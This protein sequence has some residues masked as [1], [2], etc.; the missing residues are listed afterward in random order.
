MAIKKRRPKQIVLK[1]HHQ[2]PY[3]KRQV[4]FLVLSCVVL[5]TALVKI[6]AWYGR[7]EAAQVP[8]VQ[9]VAP[10]TSNISIVRSSYGFSLAL[11]ANLFSVSATQLDSKDV[12]KTVGASDLQLN[13]PLT[14]VTIRPR[15][16][17]IERSE[18]ASQLI[19]QV[20]P[21]TSAYDTAKAKSAATASAGEVAATLFPQT[22]TNDLDV[23]ALSAKPDTLNGVPVL[24]TTYQYTP[25][26]NGGNSYATVWTGESQ[27][28][29]FAVKL[30]GLV[31]SSNMPAAYVKVLDS[32]TIVSNQG[33]KG[34]F[35]SL[36]APKVAADPSK[37]N[38]KYL[39]DDVSPA[40]VKIYHIICGTLTIYGQPAMANTC[41]GFTGSG[42]L[43]TSNGYVA[44]NGH[45]VVYSAKDRLVDVL[46]SQ[47]SLL[48][49]YLQG[50]GL[51]NSQ[52]QTAAQNPAFLASVIAKIYDVPDSDLLFTNS[53]EVTLVALGT[54]VPQF[55]SINTTADVAKLKKDNAD[56]KVA[57]I[58]A[59]NYSSKDMLTA[60]ANPTQGFSASD[61][62]L[63]KIDV[64]NAPTISVS[65][66]KPTQNEK[67]YLMGFPGDADN[68]LT[69]NTNLSVT[70][71]DGV[72]S[73]I[74]KAA[75]GFGQLYQSDA[76]ASHGNSGGPAVDESGGVIGLLTYREA[77]DSTGNAAKSYIRDITD[78][79]NLA[80][81]NNV[82]INSSSN[83]QQLWQSGLQLFSESHYSAA[84]K[85]FRQVQ[86]LYPSHRLA[87]TYIDSSKT[88]IE[89]G[90]DIRLL[91]VGV[92]VAVLVVA[93]GAVVSGV[94]MVF[95]HRLRHLLYK[96]YQPLMP[97]GKP[98]A[99][100]FVVNKDT[101]SLIQ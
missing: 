91:P 86:T 46:T 1:A 15:N 77:G 95:R 59:Y 68:A 71:T 87:A 44:T 3:R 61:V 31:G 4:L 45:V 20:N 54:A 90:K 57:K 40:V 72:I 23:S 96:A 88:A 76:D 6:G 92:I 93:V 42:F 17:T 39:S 7:K 30:V 35:T 34:A 75:G 25:K 79:T 97:E 64:H 5:A 82:A 69:D 89:Q 81:A 94:V 28:R 33:V 99:S 9:T 66:Q 8:V 27:G 84:L 11:D 24:K 43:A 18:S 53:D 56:Y 41:A 83:T 16:G 100:G 63:L 80:K 62:A 74:R 51:N 70:V 98:G 32:L 14:S 85:N 47:S 21:S 10:A 65:S 48:L 50:M 55:G 38:P 52:I 37:L 12:A 60:I 22:P 78:F 101:H 73:S 36:I 58:V 19:V 2:K 49:G 13:S 29:A 67:L 26:F